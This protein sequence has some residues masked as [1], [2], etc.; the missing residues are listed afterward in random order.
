MR[1]MRLQVNVQHAR[2]VQAVGA[3]FAGI[4]EQHLVEAISFHVPG[5]RAFA[6]VV[7]GEVERLRFATG[8]MDEL[9]ADFRHE[10][11]RPHAVEHTQSLQRPIRFGHQRLADVESRHLFALH[12]QSLGAGLSD[13]CCRRA[14]GW[15]GPHDEAVVGILRHGM[16][17]SHGEHL[18]NGTE[19]FQAHS[20]RLNRRT[21]PAAT[22]YFP[23]QPLSFSS[24]RRAFSNS[25]WANWKPAYCSLDG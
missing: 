16:D 4:F 8:L 9:H 24:A 6:R 15:A 14:A 5:A 17:R 2:F 22:W 20:F 11:P 19:R 13:E 18:Q 23:F 1:A 25:G 7:F 3:L 12:Q 21:P 10:P